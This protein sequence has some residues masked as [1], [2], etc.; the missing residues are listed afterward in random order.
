MIVYAELQRGWQGES[1]PQCL[2]T[3]ARRGRTSQLPRLWVT[4]LFVTGWK[5]ERLRRVKHPDS[6]AYYASAMQ[7][8]LVAYIV[9]SLFLDK[10]IFDLLYHLVALS[11][12]LEVVVAQ[13][14]DAPVAEIE[15]PDDEPWWRK[16]AVTPAQPS[17]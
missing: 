3:V 14:A 2:S 6:T 11:V 9:G 1:L 8:S 7:L 10:A 13:E 15:A 12:A 5:L 4:L 16:P 17:A